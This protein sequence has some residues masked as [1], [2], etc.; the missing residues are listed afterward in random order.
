MIDSTDSLLSTRSSLLS[1]LRHASDAASWQ[2][3][4]DNYGKLIFKVCR[5][6]GLDSQK[7]E[8]VTQETIVAVSQEMPKFKFDRSK[9]SFK[10][11]LWR[12]TRNHN[13]AKEQDAENYRN[14]EP[15]RSA[16][17]NIFPMRLTTWTRCGRRNGNQICWNERCNASAAKSP[18]AAIKSSTSAAFKACP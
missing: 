6:A 13:I 2:Q 18:R 5:R 14:P 9:G 8:E 12:V 3:F 17:S 7:A 11:W 10:G 15:G 1:R 16:P 4:L